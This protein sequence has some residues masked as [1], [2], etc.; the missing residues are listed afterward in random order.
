MNY[1]RE[2]SAASQA[3]SG[4]LAATSPSPGPIV[5]IIRRARITGDKSQERAARR[6]LE[7]DF[8]IRLTFHR[9]PTHD[10]PREYRDRGYK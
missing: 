4:D 8:G 6:Q 1:S 9:V 3:A 2:I 10:K 5:E 7:F